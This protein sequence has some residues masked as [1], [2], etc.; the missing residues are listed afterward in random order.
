MLSIRHAV[1]A[2][3]MAATL[4]ALAQ[5]NLPVPSVPRVTDEPFTLP[6]FPTISPF[7]LPP[8]PAPSEHAPL[9]SQLQVFVRAFRILGN[10]VLDPA[11]LQATTAP[12]VGRH[13]NTEAL[14]RLRRRLTQLYVDAGYINSGVILP[15]QTIT[16][17]VITLQVVEGALTQVNVTGLR[18]LQPGYVRD[19][20]LP[21]DT[22]LR[23]EQ[24]EDRLQL[25]NQNRLIERLNG[26]LTPGD[27][28][29]E[30]VL[31]LDVE[32]R[33]PYN[34]SFSINNHRAPSVG[35]LQGELFAAHW[36]L[37]GWGD[38]LELNYRKTEGLDDI[39]VSY[40]IPLSAH[41]TRLGVEYQYSDS[42][43]VEEPFNQL[44]IESQSSNFTVSLSHP[45]FKT[46][47]R[48][49]TLGM[50]LEKRRSETS[51]LGRA[52]SFSQGVDQGE[53]RLTVLRLRSDWVDRGENQVIAIRNTLS[54]GL[55]AFE[56]TDTGT[57]P[58]GEFFAWLGQLQW[59]RRFKDNQQL[60]FRTD[61][62]LASDALLP[63]EQFAVGG[64]SSVR[65]YRENQLVRDNG[66]ISSIELRLPVRRNETGQNT[67]QLALFADYGRAWNKDRDTPQPNSI[68]SAGL[69]L[70]WNPSP[71]WQAELYGA[72]AFRDIDSG[73]DDLQD[74]G[75]HFQLIYQPF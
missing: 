71:Q 46:V 61:V 21:I 26:Q 40:S 13:V 30:S 36:N 25:L 43:V 27:R 12:F 47:N 15:D 14:Q 20:V 62:Q 66:W 24:I 41:D 64:A 16:D 23:L 68:S 29:G 54:W 59:A 74:S 9:S 53:S 50:E 8:V 31:T 37:S 32:E 55:D 28:P 56:A 19:R 51:L 69:G 22:P 34:L 42:N 17:G 39:R 45:L 70:R 49:L 65:G 4:N 44:D 58:D 33:Q 35:S 57:E 5:S 3:L 63:L 48:S 67:L 7:T 75:I 11:Q 6:D 1:T 38:A 2:L 60:L 72:Y 18:H 52:F 73:D 10:T